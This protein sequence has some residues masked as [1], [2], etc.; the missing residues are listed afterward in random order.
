MAN[1]DGE[2]EGASASR[3]GSASQVSPGA[4]INLELLRTAVVPTPLAISAPVHQRRGDSTASVNWMQ[5]RARASQDVESFQ[6]VNDELRYAV[7]EFVRNEHG[8]EVLDSRRLL[9]T[10]R[11]QFGYSLSEELGPAQ[12]SAEQPTEP[13]SEAGGGEHVTES[14]HPIPAGGQSPSAALVIS[15][16]EISREPVGSQSAGALHDTRKRARLTCSAQSP[17]DTAASTSSASGS[18]SYYTVSWCLWSAGSS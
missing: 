6:P 13:A 9:E 2:G 15:D 12:Y 1:N 8:G 18:S 10:L 3:Q 16:D 17:H 7:L 14:G 11:D 4:S 5:V